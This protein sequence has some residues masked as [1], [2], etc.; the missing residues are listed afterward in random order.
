MKEPS[1][2][3][4]H[5][6]PLGLS[7]VIGGGLS[8]L[9]ALLSWNLELR[10]VQ[11]AFDEQ[12][13][14]FVQH[15]QRHL[16]EYV[17]VTETLGIFY[18]SSDDIT[19]QD[20]Q[21]FTRPFFNKYS[22]ILGLAWVPKVSQSERLTYEQTMKNN[23]F[24]TFKIWAKDGRPIADKPE[25]F[26]ITRGEFRKG[27]ISVIGLDLGSTDALNLPLQKAR[28]TGNIIASE[29][30]QL[31]NGGTG[32]ILY[33]PI[34]PRGSS[35]VNESQRY[36]AFLG[37]AYTVYRLEDLI[38]LTLTHFPQYQ[39]SF[40]LRDTNTNTQENLVVAFDTKNQTI[41]QL[42]DPNF[43]LPR[44]C[45]T[46][47]HCEKFLSVADRQWE[48]ISIPQFNPL[49][50]G[51]PAGIIFAVG[52]GF[53]L[54]V[55]GYLRK[56]LVEKN[57]I[58]Q[59][60]QERT[61][62]LA[63]AKE[64]LGERVKQRTAQLEAVN[65]GKNVLLGQMSHELR[66]PLNIIL[67]FIEL[68]NQDRTLTA[69][70]RENLNIMRRSSE[71]LLTLFNDILEISKLEVNAERLHETVFNLPR[72]IE[73]LIEILKLKAEAKNLQLIVDIDPEITTYIKTDENKL[74]QIL[75]NLLDNGIKF[76][77][78][79][80]ITLRLV[81]NHQSWILDDPTS[82]VT[83]PYILWFEVEDTGCGIPR[84]IQDKVFEPFFREMVTQGS[85]LG[86]SITQK[87]IHLMGGKIY[88]NSRAGKGT[89]IQFHL[90]V[91]LPEK[92][93]IPQIQSQK[94][95]I[96]LAS[97]Q[98]DYRIL[99]VDD[100]PE[101]RQLLIKFLQ[102]LG[103]KVKEA[104]NDQEALA[105]GFNWQPNLILM[106]TH[107]PVM[108]GY[109]AIQ[110]IKNLT[111]KNQI[112]IIAI[113][114]GVLENHHLDKL[115]F[116]CDDILFKPFALEKLLDKLIVHLGVKYSYEDD[117][118]E[119]NEVDSFSIHLTTS[120]FEMMSSD[121]IHQVYWAANSGDSQKIYQLIQEIPHTYPSITLGMTELVNYF[122]FRR[123]RELLY[124][125]VK[126][127]VNPNESTNPLSS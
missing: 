93:E 21:S 15:L 53:T 72:F 86:L 91:T 44:K 57:R 96:G 18:D 33:N 17:Q 8:I 116:V 64:L 23:G 42:I 27:T 4:S 6:L 45:V 46:L 65:Q 2:R 99:V 51:I 39:L 74:R 34:Y 114:S 84:E 62:A 50:V 124:P 104:T 100:Q 107:M 126:E 43:V 108:D 19:R 120:A 98:P 87:L 48:I 31:V 3:R 83:S 81:N 66:T 36:Q 61:A 11:T 24:P 12:Q 10:K 94:R 115:A 60:V 16:D 59:L 35:F 121:W 110:N 112:R 67:G 68:L 1:L 40:Y 49:L 41:N 26:P 122:N 47:F 14:H 85:G 73:S 89:I 117:V 77:E 69:E 125:L 54:L 13:E 123:I 90:P 71:Y 63:Q 5:Y 111:Q 97:E 32:F 29:L 58:E 79:G 105:I 82:D 109:R 22:G 127:P 52:L 7:L 75:I 78:K 95:V 9:A 28:K 56:T 92:E 20:F 103:F 30:F 55:T 106:D 76:T 70:Q 80:S 113:I 102:P 38:K 101:N 25:Y 119:I 88:L 37:T 118:V